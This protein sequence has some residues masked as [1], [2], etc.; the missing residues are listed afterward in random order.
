MMRRWALRILL[1]GALVWLTFAA[2]AR[3]HDPGMSAATLVLETDRSTV[4]ISIKGSDLPSFDDGDLVDEAG[5]VDDA[6]LEL[7]ADK[8]WEYLEGRTWMSATA[9]QCHSTRAGLSAIDDGVLAVV[10][11]D[12]G[13]DQQGLSYRTALLHDKLPETLQHLLI[14]KGDQSVPAVLTVQE[15]AIELTLPPDRATLIWRYADAG[16]D[17]L[18]QGYD[19]IA[20]LTA[21]VLWARRFLP[22]V[23]VVTA[24]TIA[25]AITLFLAATQTINVPPYIVEPLISLTII[26][27]GLHNLFSRNVSTRWLS[28]LFLGLIHGFGFAAAL[29]DLGLSDKSL[30][31]ALI[32]FNLGIE[33]GQLL[34]VFALAL[35]LLIVDRLTTPQPSSP[36]RSKM[37]VY[38]LSTLICLMGCYWFIQRLAANF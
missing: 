11:F 13:T 17:H 15:P 32:G 37:I 1:S 5:L 14:L 22:L 12:C 33:I 36:R 18:F 24:F 38:G 10:Q 31:S 2:T 35:T 29:R 27:A 3:A 19:H 21:L 7:S 8:V 20:F 4:E 26:I 30:I 23:K 25:H 16:V 9:H 34:Y 28:A 6:M